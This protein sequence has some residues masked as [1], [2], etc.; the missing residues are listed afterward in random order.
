MLDLHQHRKNRTATIKTAQRGAIEG[1]NKRQISLN[2]RRKKPLSETAAVCVRSFLSSMQRSSRNGHSWAGL[3]AFQVCLV[4]FQFSYCT[5][6]FTNQDEQ[7]RNRRGW[8]TRKPLRLFVWWT[9]ATQCS[10]AHD[11]KQRSPYR[12]GRILLG[13][14][15]LREC[16]TSAIPPWLRC[17]TS[18]TP[19]R[20]SYFSQLLHPP[21]STNLFGQRYRQRKKN[22][23]KQQ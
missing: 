4:A 3:V 19:S 11:K 17:L 8:D 15:C 21:A 9:T 6:F 7:E 10:T 2:L 18:T 12:K 13:A 16:S 5:V 22:K 14:R 20:L 23:R 1:H